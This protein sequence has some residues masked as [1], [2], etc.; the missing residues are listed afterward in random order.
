MKVTEVAG[1]RCWLVEILEQ[2][3]GRVSESRGSG[4]TPGA[5]CQDNL[6]SVQTRV[7]Q[8]RAVARMVS[9][10]ILAT[11]VAACTG[12]AVRFPGDEAVD[13]TEVGQVVGGVVRCNRIKGY[14]CA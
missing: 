2:V 9:R 7:S 12:Q 4:S 3:P 10:I 1:A 13:M 8:T 11:L 14:A 6:L 5:G